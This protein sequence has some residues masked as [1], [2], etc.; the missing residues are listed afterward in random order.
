MIVHHNQ[1]IDMGLPS[2]LTAS[3]TKRLRDRHCIV[4]ES[5]LLVNFVSI[6]ADAGMQV[7]TRTLYKLQFNRLPGSWHDPP[8]HIVC[9]A[10]PS[11]NSSCLSGPPLPR[12]GERGGQNASRDTMHACLVKKQAEDSNGVQDKVPWQFGTRIGSGK[13]LLCP[14]MD[15]SG[16]GWL[17]Q[18]PRHRCGGLGLSRHTP[19]LDDLVL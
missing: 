9:I 13:P 15:A 16:T 1:Q 2:V 10:H 14:Q 3:R 4:I 17:P 8:I 18:F 19:E 5:K 11:K 6:L 7:R 12:R